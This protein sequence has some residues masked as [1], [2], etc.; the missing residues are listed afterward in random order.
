MKE[1]KLKVLIADDHP[2]LR[3][4]LRAVINAHPDMEVV[5]E[6]A[7]GASVLGAVSETTP[8]VAVIDVSMP[9]VGGAEA[10]EQVRRHRPEVK[11]V[12]LSGHEGRGHVQRMLAA[13]ATGYV[14]KRT[15]LEEL[16]RAIR[17][18]AR[19]STYLDPLVAGSLDPGVALPEKRPV[20]PELSER[21]AEVL[22]WIARGY[23]MKEIS[24]AI[25]VG[26]RT[27][28]TYK[29]RAMA[30]LGLE[31]RADIVRLAVERGWLDRD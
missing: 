13:G 9:Q 22:G 24:A 10:T 7:D 4:G 21:E 30:K 1:R 19:G 29:A 17:C 3:R 27:V 6:V 12:A 15:G 18:V 26:V 23:S 14:V 20:T 5:G 16:V 31:S 11:I 28:E 2:V 25:D 8:D